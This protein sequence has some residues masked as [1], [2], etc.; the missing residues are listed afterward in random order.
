MG[1]GTSE[2]SVDLNYSVTFWLYGPHP[3]IHIHAKHTIQEGASE[4][5]QPFQPLLPMLTVQPRYRWRP[6]LCLITLVIQGFRSSLGYKVEAKGKSRA[7]DPLDT[8]EG[9]AIEE[10]GAEPDHSA[11]EHASTLIAS[12]MLFVVLKAK[13][14]LMD[15]VGWE[16]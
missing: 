1:R 5:L 10:E 8:L 3:A 16:S 6:L 15:L 9:S 14:R 4:E 2:M 12:V 7:V 11:S 13:H